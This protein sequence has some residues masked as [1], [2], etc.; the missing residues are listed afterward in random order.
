MGAVAAPRRDVARLNEDA[1]GCDGRGTRDALCQCFGCFGRVVGCCD[2]ERFGITGRVFCTR[3]VGCVWRAGAATRATRTRV[4]CRDVC[5]ERVTLL[6]L[7]ALVNTHERSV[8]CF[9]R[10][11]VDCVAVSNCLHRVSSFIQM[12]AR[13]HIAPHFCRLW[14]S[15][16]PTNAKTILRRFDG[17]QYVLN[18]S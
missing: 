14:Y 5:L 2:V 9:C 12:P 13:L 15:V 16:T 3:G 4:C 6:R 18:V 1:C 7:F 8:R 11:I 17:L 10:V